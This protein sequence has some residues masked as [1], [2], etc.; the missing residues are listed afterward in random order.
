MI[1]ITSGGCSKQIKDV[2]CEIIAVSGT[3]IPFAHVRDCRH[4]M[5]VTRA[6]LIVNNR[7]VLPEM[8]YTQLQQGTYTRR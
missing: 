2:Y 3:K 8:Q 7:E 4:A 5:G 1:Q 6:K